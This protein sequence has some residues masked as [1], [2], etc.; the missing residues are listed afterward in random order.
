MENKLTPYDEAYYRVDFETAK[1]LKQAGFGG[2]TNAFYQSPNYELEYH[3]ATVDRNITTTATSAPLIAVALEW[4]KEKG[5]KWRTN[6]GGLIV[7][8]GSD[9]AN[10]SKLMEK[11]YDKPNYGRNLNLLFITTCCKHLIETWRIT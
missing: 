2:K 8:N 5:Y 10:I 6:H 1:L 7:C 3:E 9:V 11:I 4:L